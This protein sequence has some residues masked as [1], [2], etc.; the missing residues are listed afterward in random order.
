MAASKYPR[1]LY[2]TRPVLP[3]DVV[4]VLEGESLNQQLAIAASDGVLLVDGFLGVDWNRVKEHLKCLPGIAHLDFLY[5]T[6]AMLPE[7]RIDTL[8]ALFL[9]NDDPVFGKLYQGSL[10]DFFQQDAIRTF[11]ARVAK[12]GC[13]VLGVG[14]ALVDEKRP[15]IYLDVSKESLQ[16][17][18]CTAVNLGQATPSKTNFYKR[19][20]FVDWPVL[21]RY[22]D[23]IRSRISL[24]IDA[25]DSNRW[26]GL[27]GSQLRSLIS[28]TAHR[29][30][31]VKPW[32]LPG[33]WGGQFM[34]GH[35]GLNSNAPNFAWSYE[36]IAPEN[37][38]LVGQASMSVELPFPFMIAQEP[39]AY[40]GERTA[41][42][43]G[44]NFPIRFDYLDTIDGGNLSLQCH[45]SDSF[46]R[47]QFGEP[48]TQD[49]AYYI[50]DCQEGSTVYL[51]FRED[52]NLSEFWE[53]A[54]LSQ[55]KGRPF[56]IDRFVSAWP[57][58]K[59]DL[60]LIP[61]GTVHCSG[62]GNLV[63][64]ISATPYI[65][66][67]KI[68][69][70]LRKDLAGN[71]RPLHIKYAQINA[72]PERTT[73]WTKS[74]L[75]PVPRLISQGADWKIYELCSTPL[76]FYA[77]ERVEFSSKVCGSTRA[78][79]EVVNLVEGDQIQIISHEGS[80][81]LHYAE[82]AIIPASAGTYVLQND[83][84]STAKLLKAFVKP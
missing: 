4:Q 37:G 40:L 62:R 6:N 46:I 78:G 22:R 34:K 69:D 20:Y 53:A 3:I 72:R 60:F 79:V 74:D 57:S 71:L 11:Q 26:L 49:E 76:L 41:Q 54:H 81:E 70:Y 58:R 59:H 80:L 13:A 25:N 67:F 12:G 66:T 2:Q 9:N 44:K 30:F 61:N 38:V 39:K 21:E 33:P 45:P 1:G 56:E 32:F 31:R 19:A 29:P 51:G 16:T 10:L 5:T 14:A 15:V 47:S 35:M 64:E 82:T 17:G 50:H 48:F 65:Y 27:E 83:S 42:R 73:H 24:W 75:I 68:Y 18:S 23:T 43:F 63:L 52:A 8:I 28:S 7:H 77:M 36:L 55:A 84:G